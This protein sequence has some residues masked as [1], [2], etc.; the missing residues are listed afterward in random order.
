MLVQGKKDQS[1]HKIENEGKKKLKNCY[2]ENKS[3][4]ALTKPIKE[5]RGSNKIRNRLQPTPQKNK[6]SEESAEHSYLLIKQ[7]T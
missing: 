6:C 7:T 2:L 5:K 4:K 1:G 3:N